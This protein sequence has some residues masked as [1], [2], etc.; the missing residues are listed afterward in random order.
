MYGMHRWFNVVD[1]QGPAARQ[2][3]TDMTLYLR[4]LGMST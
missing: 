4:D 1:G 3:L 2:Y